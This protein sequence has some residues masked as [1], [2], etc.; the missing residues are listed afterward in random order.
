M[1][2]LHGFLMIEAVLATLLFS[3]LGLSIAQLSSSSLTAMAA[4]RTGSIA[5]N[6][7]ELEINILK[8]TPYD[9]LSSAAHGKQLVADSNGIYTAVALGTERV[10]SD[11]RYRTAVVNVYPSAS[12]TTPT[13]TLSVPL[14]SKGITSV[15]NQ[16]E[17]AAQ[18]MENKVQSATDAMNSKISS[19]KV[20]RCT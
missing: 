6:Y 4:T 2:K 19:L 20:C 12:S 16:V 3:M 17:A 9:N 18:D 5:Q 13:Y 1:K 7:A 14:S 11:G 10:L 15:L 8:E